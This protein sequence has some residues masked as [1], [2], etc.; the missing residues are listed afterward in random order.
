MI[1]ATDVKEFVIGEKRMVLAK[2]NDLIDYHSGKTLLHF[3]SVV[4]RHT[5]RLYGENVFAKGLDGYPKAI[6]NG[7]LKEHWRCYIKRVIDE[8]HLLVGISSPRR[9]AKMDYVGNV[10]WEIEGESGAV[11]GCTDEVIVVNMGETIETEPYVFLTTN[12]FHFI[13]IA[14]GE[15]FHTIEYGAQA[16]TSIGQIGKYVWLGDLGGALTRC[17]INTGELFTPFVSDALMQEIRAHNR[18]RFVLEKYDTSGDMFINLFGDVD[19]RTQRF[20]PRAYVQI[21]EDKYPDID[22][23]G[24]AYNQEVLAFY[25]H[26]S[27]T[28][29]GE[30]HVVALE[31]ATGKLL[32][33]DYVHPERI[34]IWIQ[35]MEMVGNQLIYLDT[36]GFLHQIDLKATE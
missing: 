32:Y 13:K 14:S 17:N 23:F 4:N 25:Y 22:F 9:I 29:M 28:P 12:T 33:E 30:S 26:I 15:V 8:N 27:P 18:P 2:G 34:S 19:L 35:Q 10:L 1:I 20:T 11:I 31:R 5:T 16:P 21:L 3:D 7:E 36:A 6:I 24:L